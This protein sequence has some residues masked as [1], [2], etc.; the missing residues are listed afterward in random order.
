V[1]K[2]QQETLDLKEFKEFKEFKASKALLDRQV[3]K[4]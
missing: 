3:H 2:A 4:V 1:Y